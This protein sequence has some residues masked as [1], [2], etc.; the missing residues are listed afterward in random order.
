MFLFRSSI[1]QI[2]ALALLAGVASPSLSG[3]QDAN[4]LRKAVPPVARI[5]VSPE[6][7]HFTEPLNDDGLVNLEA[8]LN[9]HFGNGVS[10]EN[11]AAVVLYDVLGPAPEG[12]RLSDE[13]FRQLGVAVPPDD[14]NFFLGLDQWIKQSAVD[15]LQDV[16]TSERWNGA[17]LRD[18]RD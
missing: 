1:R 10:P 13:F 14:G 15:Q 4:E 6:T 9:R 8:A 18:W 16:L 12:T 2:L 7:T 3:A 11:N 17:R 5:L